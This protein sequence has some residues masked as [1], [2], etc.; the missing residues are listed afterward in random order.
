MR[1]P[2][3]GETWMLRPGSGA[4]GT[5]GALAWRS[6]GRVPEALSPSCGDG[7]V[8][9]CCQRAGLGCRRRRAV[10]GVRGGVSVALPGCED[11]VLG[12]LSVPRLRLK[13]AGTAAPAEHQSGGETR[14]SSRRVS[15]CVLAAGS[16][17]CE[18][19]CSAAAAAPASC[20]WA[21]ATHRQSA[22]CGRRATA[23]RAA[24]PG[25]RPSAV[26]WRH[27]GPSRRACAW[28]SPYVMY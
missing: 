27:R 2:L 4:K 18:E 11:A 10:G 24:P 1:P 23:G 13:H 6:A 25:W 20:P 26:G 22:P 7:G 19:A 12:G 9:P 5:R 14:M 17:S 21:W 15:G 28:R 16:S 8:R 3:C